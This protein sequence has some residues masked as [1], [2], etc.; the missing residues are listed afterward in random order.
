MNQIEAALNRNKGLFSRITPFNFNEEP[1]FVF[2]FTKENN[3]LANVDLNNEQSFNDY[4]FGSLASANCKVGVGGY[5]ENRTIYSRSDVF[6]DTENR[7]LHLG[8]DVWA[9]AG[10]P[11]YAP[12]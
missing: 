9:E 11:I 5:G 6:S 3:A 1:Y 4:I 7:S 12:M 10:T 8:I 2:D